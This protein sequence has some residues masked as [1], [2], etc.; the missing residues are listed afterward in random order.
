MFVYVVCIYKQRNTYTEYTMINLY[1]CY[2]GGETKSSY[3]Y[4]YQHHN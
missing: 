2:A 1:I 3:G 4:C